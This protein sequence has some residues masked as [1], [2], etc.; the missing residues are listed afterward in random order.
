MPNRHE[1][2]KDGD[3][4]LHLSGMCLGDGDGDGDCAEGEDVDEKLANYEKVANDELQVSSKVLILASPVFKAMLD[5]NFMEATE[6]ARN[7]GFT[8]PYSIDLPDDDVEAMI[9]LCQILHFYVVKRP[10]LSG[11]SKLAFISDKYE[12]TQALNY[13]GRVWISDWLQ[14]Y[15]RNVPPMVD[16]C[17]LLVFSYVVDLPLEFSEISWRI[18]LHHE[19]PFL[20]TS[21]QVKVLADHPL[22]RHDIIRTSTPEFPALVSN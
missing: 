18:F 21:D 1:I 15:D 11:L 3:L 2:D 5:G 16:F 22:L 17:H 13:C 6:L 8:N 7:T 20:P 14:E 9:T 4:I 12:C 10:E 19:G